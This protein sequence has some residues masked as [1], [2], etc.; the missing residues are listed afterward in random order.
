MVYL[1]RNGI[2]HYSW[3]SAQAFSSILDIPNPEKKPMAELWMGSHPKLSSSVLTAKGEVSLQDLINSDPVLVLGE[4]IAKRFNN[5]LPFL[6]KVLAAETPLSVQSHP[7][8][9]QAK[10]GFAREDGQS[11]PI[12]APNRNYRDDNH[13]PEI[14]CAVTPYTAMCGFR[15]VEQILMELE[16]F[17]AQ[18]LEHGPDYL[19]DNPTQAGLK[20]FY[21]DLMDLSGPEKSGFIEKAI[22]YSEKK[23]GLC[24]QWPGKL[25]KLYPNDIGAVMPLFLNIRKLQPGQALYL[26]AGELHA[27]LE[28]VGIELMANSDNVLRGGLTP[29]H[30]DIP[31]LLKVL[32]FNAVEPDVMEIPASQDF[33]TYPTVASEFLLSRIKLQNSR[34]QRRAKGPEILLNLSASSKVCEKGK[35]A[36]TLNKGQS[37]FITNNTEYTLSGEGPGFLASVPE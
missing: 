35:E 24:Y 9:E 31:E 22:E 27:Y 17:C 29:K 12:D 1:M 36:I 37:C 23:E 26:G 34:I 16:G 2:Q 6:L 30:V 10:E 32:T 5:K 8:L 11:I 25:A 19:R 15:P 3:G 14:I 33:Y 18:E 21:K 28:G 20:A 13:K 4:G 7:S